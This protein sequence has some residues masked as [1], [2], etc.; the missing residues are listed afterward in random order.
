MMNKIKRVMAIVMM[1]CMLLT[2]TTVS[3]NTGIM[4]CGESVI[5]NSREL[6]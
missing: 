3:S 1:G 5:T 4:P 6:V 2:F